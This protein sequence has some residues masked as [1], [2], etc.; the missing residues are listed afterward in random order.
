[1]PLDTHPLLAPAGLQIRRLVPEEAQAYRT[2]RLEGLRAHPD[3][4]GSSWDEEA[5]LPPGHYA[6][7]LAQGAVFAASIGGDD[8]AGVA[9]LM[10]P[11]A[12]KQSH[13]G[14]LWGVYVPPRARGRKVAAALVAHVLEHARGR[15]LECVLLTV[16]AHNA[17]AQRL[18]RAA[19]FVPYGMEPRALEVDGRHYDEVLMRCSLRS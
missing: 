3:A 11:Q 5:A 16:G 10:V 6:E 19:G 15:G 2:L 12:R 13:K 7:R 9:G 14:V 8:W 18:Y 1:M 17:A 4:F